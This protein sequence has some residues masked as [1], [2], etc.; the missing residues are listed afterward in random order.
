M[1]RA[2]IRSKKRKEVNESI[3]LVLRIYNLPQRTIF[4]WLARYRNGWHALTESNRKGRPTK[5]SGEDMRWLYNAVTMGN[6]Q[7]YKL[8]FCLWTLNTIRTLLEKER[9]S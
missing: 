8:P 7:N 4:R 2:D 5:V 3:V 6:P 1:N 9:L